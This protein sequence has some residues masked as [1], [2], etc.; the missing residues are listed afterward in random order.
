MEITVCLELLKKSKGTLLFSLGYLFILDFCRGVVKVILK[1]DN[2]EAIFRLMKLCFYGKRSIFGLTYSTPLRM[3]IKYM[4]GTH[5]ESR[6][7][8]ELNCF[9]LSDMAKL[10]LD[11][12]VQKKG[13][14]IECKCA[15]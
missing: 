12:C 4:P 1:M 7:L 15:Y 10:F 3:L 2:K 11:L 14:Y 6:R 9:S 8:P 13:K 5:Y